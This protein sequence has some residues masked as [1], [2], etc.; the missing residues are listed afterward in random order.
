[1]NEGFAHNK[2]AED[3][4]EYELLEKYSQ[5][6][7]DEAKLSQA[8]PTKPKQ[9]KT[10]ST[11]DYEFTQC[12]AYGPVTRGNGQVESSLTQPSTGLACSTNDGGDVYEAV[13]EP[14]S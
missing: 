5:P 14:T 10:A 8:P 4:H 7:R 12:P 3:D 2:S 9:L 13:N 11:G 6:N 1:M